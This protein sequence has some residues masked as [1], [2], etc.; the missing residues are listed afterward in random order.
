MVGKLFQYD[1]AGLWKP[2]CWGFAAE[3]ALALLANLTFSFIRSDTVQVFI[4]IAL[5]LFAFAI[6][7]VCFVACLRQF[8]ESCYGKQGYLTFTLPVHPWQILTA[9]LSSSVLILL[10]TLFIQLLAVAIAVPFRIWTDLFMDEAFWNVIRHLA[11]SM[12]AGDWFKIALTLLHLLLSGVLSS[13]NSFLIIFLSMSI[14]QLANNYR[15]PIS[16]AAFFVLT[17]L[18]SL[19]SLLLSN[20]LSAFGD[21]LSLPSITDPVSAFNLLIGL[22]DLYNLAIGALLFWGVLWIMKNRLNLE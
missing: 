13:A 15:V 17:E 8:Y 22:T 20:G 4:V 1:F 6:C 21:P 3:L 9:R 16:F 19:V 10:I 11:A 7:I 14:G 12:D 5:A 18:N 2:V